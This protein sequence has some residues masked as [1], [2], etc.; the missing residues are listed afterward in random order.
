MVKWVK[1]PLQTDWLE[2]SYDVTF[3]LEIL[4]DVSAVCP[5]AFIVRGKQFHF[6]RSSCVKLFFA[7]EMC[8]FSKKNLALV[9][10]DSVS[11]GWDTDHGISGIHWQASEATEPGGT[12]SSHSIPTGTQLTKNMLFKHMEYVK[13]L[14]LHHPW[15]RGDHSW[16]FLPTQF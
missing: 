5:Q 2:K 12:E 7:T 15:G 3:E 9:M 16:G 6:W 8:E 11:T 14:T 1:L 4:Y 10:R 13:V